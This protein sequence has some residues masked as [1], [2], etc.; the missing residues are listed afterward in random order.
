[1]SYRELAN[2][3]FGTMKK[4]IHM[5]FQK[6]VGDITRGERR[7]LGFLTFEGDGLTA[8]ELSEKLNFSTPRIASVLKSLEKKR[9][10]E[11]VRDSRDK[12]FVVVHITA[13]GRSFVL[14]EQEKAMIML[15]EL[16][17]ELG[18][19]D[20]KELIRIMGRIAEITNKRE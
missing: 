1:M 20:T 3:L 5:P 16:L 12:R 14:E 10:I 15:E 17:R 4:I 8:G 13:T 19:K 11:R 9:F 7:I 6:K 2:E 18:E